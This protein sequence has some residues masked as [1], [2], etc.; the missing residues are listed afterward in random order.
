MAQG[1]MIPESRLPALMKKYDRLGSRYVSYPT[2]PRFSHDFDVR[3]TLRRSWART[4][5]MRNLTL[6][7]TFI[8]HSATSSSISVP[9]RPS[10]FGPAS[11]LGSI[12]PPEGGGRPPVFPACGWATHL[13]VALGRWYSD[14]YI[15]GRNCRCRLVYPQTVCDSRRCGSE[16]RASRSLSLARPCSGAQGC[17]IK[18]CQR[19]GTRF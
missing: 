13:S 1:G 3:G 7:S 14:M 10:P 6:H 15:A 8:F 4:Q 18:P 17:W 5:E 16:R 2:A 9:V 12:W 11:A 19:G